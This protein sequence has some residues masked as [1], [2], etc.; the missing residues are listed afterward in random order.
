MSRYALGQLCTY[1]LCLFSSSVSLTHSHTYT[2]TC[3]FLWMQIHIHYEHT[4]PQVTVLRIKQAF[5]FII[6]LVQTHKIFTVSVPPKFVFLLREEWFCWSYL[7]RDFCESLLSLYSLLFLN[8]YIEQIKIMKRHGQK[9]M[10]EEIQI[11]L[12]ILHMHL[13]GS[14]K[15]IYFKHAVCLIE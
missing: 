1:L 8:S 11:L 10:S 6:V 5:A 14:P 9:Y 12:K 4:V 3:L 7:G 15:I 2:N 13:K